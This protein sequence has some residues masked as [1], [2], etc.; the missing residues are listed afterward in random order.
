LLHEALLRLLGHDSAFNDR[1]HF[2]R[3]AARAMRR[4]LVDHARKVAAGTRIPLQARFSV[5]DVTAPMEI[6]CL[7]LLDLDR[8]LSKLAALDPD[9]AQVVELRCFAG[10]TIPEV[11]TLQA[12]SEATVSREWRHAKAWLRRSLTEPRSCSS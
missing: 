9:L 1:E 6:P 4:I 3:A 11:A 8:A 5:E 12:V 10:L 7:D 2:F